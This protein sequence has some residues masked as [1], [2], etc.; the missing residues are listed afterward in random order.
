MML[1]EVIALPRDIKTRYNCIAKLA[2]KKNG[3]AQLFSNVILAKGEIR[4]GITLVSHQEWVNDIYRRF[5]G[6]I[7]SCTVGLP[8]YGQCNVISFH[9]PAWP[10]KIDEG[11]DFSEIKLKLN[12]ELWLTEILWALLRDQSTSTNKR[13]IVG[14]DFNSSE[15]FDYMW[16]GGPRGNLEIINRMN[17]LELKECLRSYNRQLVPTFK[18]ASNGRIIHQIDHLYVSTSIYDR[19]RNCYVGDSAE[20]F[21]KQLSDHLP[22]VADFNFIDGHAKLKTFSKV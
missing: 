9:S 6:N 3:T 16:K 7:L 14:G 1:Q 18:N 12:P 15:T 20:I 21:D 10:I 5:G 13:W 8:V 19:L 17:G 22:I 4:D 2:T 11:I